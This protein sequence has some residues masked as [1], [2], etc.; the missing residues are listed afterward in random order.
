MKFFYDLD[1]GD[2]ILNLTSIPTWKPQNFDQYDDI[3]M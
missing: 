1:V 3:K 2:A